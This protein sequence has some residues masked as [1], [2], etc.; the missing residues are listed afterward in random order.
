MIVESSIQH[1][2]ADQF[3]PSDRYGI[4]LAGKYPGDVSSSTNEMAETMAHNRTRYA[5]RTARKLNLTSMT[6][7][8]S[9]VVAAAINVETTI[10]PNNPSTVATDDPAA[11]V[12]TVKSP[13]HVHNATEYLA[14]HDEL[15]HSKQCV[16]MREGI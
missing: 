4:C 5:K 2:P 12:T 13:H 1:R 8:P 10:H 6:F 3:H 16:I 9:T 7:L 15:E 14:E 11:T